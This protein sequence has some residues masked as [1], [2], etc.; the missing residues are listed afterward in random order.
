MIER[1]VAEGLL[2][3]A[4]LSHQEFHPLLRSFLRQR[5]R[6][7]EPDAWRRLCDA[8]ISDSRSQNKWEDAFEIAVYSAELSTATEILGEAAPELLAEGRI[9]TLERWL[10]ACP[11]ITDSPREPT[12][13]PARRCISARE[14]TSLPRS[15]PRRSTG[16]PRT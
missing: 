15:M 12:I 5:L 3:P 13:L 1:L 9:E 2:Q 11:Q 10:E 8:A 6:V 14:A 4:G 7:E 16:L